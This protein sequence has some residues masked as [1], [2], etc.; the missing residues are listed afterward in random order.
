MPS[1]IPAC[2]TRRRRPGRYRRRTPPHAS[3]DPADGPRDAGHG[4]PAAWYCLALAQAWSICAHPEWGA[5]LLRRFR[6]RN[7]RRLVRRGAEAGQAAEDSRAAVPEP[8]LAAPGQQHIR[9]RR[10]R[11]CGRRGRARGRRTRLRSRPGRRRGYAASG[12][13]AATEPRVGAAGRV[14][15][16]LPLPGGDGADHDRNGAENRDD[17]RR[18]RTVALRPRV[19]RCSRESFVH[20]GTRRRGRE[21]TAPPSIDVSAHNP[22][23]LWLLKR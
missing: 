10:P 18:D 6:S 4:S 13:R 3:V 14:G 2:G 1:R 16:L 20:V 23:A 12:C 21:G 8:S 15:A 5:C 17:E 9:R 11:L 22:T 7:M 19:H